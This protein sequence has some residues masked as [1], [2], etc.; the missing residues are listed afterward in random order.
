MPG[1]TD[2]K[3]SFAA[4][5]SRTRLANPGRLDLFAVAV[6]APVTCGSTRAASPLTFNGV[7][8][9]HQPTVARVSM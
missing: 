3:V 1:R 2:L 6:S 5:I 4:W 8:P 9:G 7:A